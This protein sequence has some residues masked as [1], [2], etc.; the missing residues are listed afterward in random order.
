MSKYKAVFF[1]LDHTLWDFEMNSQSAIHDL[2]NMH[3][4]SDLG[5]SSA[6]DFISIYRDIN[7]RMWDEYHRNKITKEMLRSGRF[8]RTLECFGI[9]DQK[10]AEVLATNYLQ[11]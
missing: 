7:H 3:N 6:N 9:H 1:D 8:K 2:F 4:L 11:N 5:V 10:L